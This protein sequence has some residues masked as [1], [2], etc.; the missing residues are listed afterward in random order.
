[1]L[2]VDWLNVQGSYSWE[3]FK[4]NLNTGI[5]LTFKKTRLAII[6]SLVQNIA[7]F[8]LSIKAITAGE[9]ECDYS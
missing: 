5:S 9:T 8:Q 3:V 2:H 7:Q 6:V 1:M 4:Y